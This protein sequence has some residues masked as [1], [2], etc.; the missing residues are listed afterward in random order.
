MSYRKPCPRTLDRPIV[1]FGL[2]PE[3]FVFV[4]LVSGAI[5]FT[6]DPV[7]AVIAGAVLWVGLSRL[8][9]GKPPG[10]LY[11]LAH[12]SGLLRWAPGF[13]RVPH[14]LPPGLTHLDAFPGGDDGILRQYRYDRPGLDPGSDRAP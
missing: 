1:V 7:P 11:E 10:Y 3:E 8:K 13:L 2:E 6:I 14:L 5:L 12:R 4:G 9:A